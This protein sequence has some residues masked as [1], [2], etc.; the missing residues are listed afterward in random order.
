MKKTSVTLMKQ[1]GVATKVISLITGTSCRMLD[2]IYFQ[3]S[4]KV[5]R[6]AAE[7]AFSST[8]QGISSCSKEACADQEACQQFCTKCGRSASPGWF[9]CPACGTELVRP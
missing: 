3:P 5:Q 8:A 6:H 2:N 9:F 1:A 7:A 4:R